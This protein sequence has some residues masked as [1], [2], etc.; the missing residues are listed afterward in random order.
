[1]GT[2]RV[3]IA[4]G[5]INKNGLYQVRDVSASQV[6]KYKDAGKLGADFP[7][8]TIDQSNDLIDGFTRYEALIQLHDFR[9]KVTVVKLNF[10]D[11]IERLEYAASEN[12]KNGYGLQPIEEKRLAFRLERLGA[13]KEKISKAIGR[14]VKKILRWHN[15][16]LIVIG[17]KGE[18]SEPRK[19]GVDKDI[20]KVTK[21][22]FDRIEKEVSGWMPNFHADQIILHI[23]NKTLNFKNEQTVLK[24]Q[25]LVEVIAKALEERSAS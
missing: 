24:L 20:K 2:N 16:A 12:N 1:M 10:K 23:E 14:P 19:R 15:E 22:Q 5:D 21:E 7:P 9:Y 25:E 8:M 13:D 4:L 17:P 11:D 3:R 18:H 6:V